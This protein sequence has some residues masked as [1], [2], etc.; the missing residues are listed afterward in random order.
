MEDISFAAFKALI[1]ANQMLTAG[2]VS[3]LIS[4]VVIWKYWEEVSYFLIRM[5]HSMPLIGTVARLARRPGTV[6]QDGWINHEVTL[7]NAYYREY[8]K[9][10]KGPNDYESAKDYLAKAGESGRSKRPLWVFFLVVT[11]ILI[12]AMGFA[13]V[14]AGWMNMDASTND[15]HWLT[16]GTAALLAIASAGLAEVTGHAIHHNNLVARARHWW[17]GEEP[18]KRSRTLQSLPPIDLAKSFEDN[19]KPIYEQLLSRVDNVKPQVT[20]RYTAMATCAAFVIFMAVGAFVVRSFALES[21]ETEMVNSMK[22]E[23]MAQSGSGVGS[24][25]DLPEESQAINDEADDQTIQDKMDAIRAA[26]LTTYVMLSV[27]YL[28]IQFISIWLASRYHFAGVHSKVAYRL[29]HEFA[30]LEEM[31]EAMDQKRIAIAS[32]ADDKIRRL[33]TAMRDRQATDNGVYSALEGENTSH[34]NF[35]S[36][37][38]FKAGKVTQRKQPIAPAQAP[39]P[40]PA[41]AQAATI[42][43]EDSPAQVAAAAPAAAPAIEVVEP[44]SAPTPAAA[45]AIKAGDYHDVTGLSDESIAAASRGL[46]LSEEQLRDIRDQQVALRSIGLFPAK[47]EVTV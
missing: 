45:P 23:V 41:P 39:A 36:F 40:A 6:D 8:K 1:L 25:F 30:T 15:R 22:S 12:E 13:Y 5:W 4:A 20:G 32:H 14:L 29:S 10:V 27:I 26:S 3:L 24:P 38:E 9:H 37:L 11:L 16:A 18:S 28:A 47:K 2:I 33:Q 34:R 21:I 43:T 17:Q 35:L 44:A 42:P 7:C 46:G 19:D 31:M